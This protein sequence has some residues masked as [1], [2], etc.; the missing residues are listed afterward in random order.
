MSPTS[1]KY[2]PLQLQQQQ[3]QQQRDET[4]HE[5]I[6]FEYEQC[7]PTT[8][9]NTMMDNNMV[10]EKINVNGN[11]NHNENINTG[12]NNNNN[13]HTMTHSID[14]EDSDT[15]EISGGQLIDNHTIKTHLHRS[16]Y[17]NNNN[18]N[19]KIIKSKHIRLLKQN[20][21]ELLLNNIYH[22]HHHLHHRNITQ[23]GIFKE[24]NNNSSVVV[25][26]LVDK[27]PMFSYL[28]EVLD[29]YLHFFVRLF[30]VSM[31]FIVIIYFFN[32]IANDVQ[33]KYQLHAA[34]LQKEIEACSKNYFDN[35]C[36][37]ETRL[38][39]M[40]D[41][42]AQWEICMNKDPSS[43][44]KSKLFAEL[45]SEVLDSLVMNMSYRTMIF[46]LVVLW[47]IVWVPN[48][49]LSST[50]RPPSSIQQQAH[51]PPTSPHPAMHT[52]SLDQHNR[53]QD[54]NNSLVRY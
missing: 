54:M 2:S 30:I 52:Q 11:G 1:F 21:K 18:N 43:L 53:Q 3:Q 31:I 9:S 16:N 6:P 32:A 14:D 46:S 28:P 20:N 27:E 25:P 39:A 35:K 37:P 49:V 51:H 19:N 13:V 24:S 12:D 23:H 50:N 36:L 48:K 47:L 15:D 33:L 29:R 45:V 44:P 4:M 34:Q 8:S 17:S 7:L 41:M 42:C 10:N 22:H 40:V 26:P 38:P 5:P